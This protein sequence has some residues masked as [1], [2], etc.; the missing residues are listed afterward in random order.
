MKDHLNNNKVYKEVN[1][2]EDTKVFQELMDHVKNMKS[3][4]PKTK[5]NISHNTNGR[6][7]ISIHAQRFTNAHRSY[8][9]LRNYMYYQN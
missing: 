3:I 5:S 4:S 8:K 1:A 7:V 6:A 9:R 2:N